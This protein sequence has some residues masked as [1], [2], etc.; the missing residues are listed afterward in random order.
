[1]I[2]GW[3][4]PKHWMLEGKLMTKHDI[5]RH[6]IF[7]QSL[8][9]S[10]R[11]IR[12]ADCDY[13]FTKYLLGITIVTLINQSVIM[14]MM[15]CRDAGICH[16]SNLYKWLHK[17][18]W[19]AREWLFICWRFGQEWR[20][21]WSNV[22]PLPLSHQRNMARFHATL[23]WYT[24]KPHEEFQAILLIFIHFPHEK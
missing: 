1:M 7:R 13:G 22:G 17:S 14:L 20:N 8:A 6:P 11:A 16:G 19:M 9:W 15:A 5:F 3:W 10:K 12:N 24:S 23:I 2:V 21:I 4:F 18:W